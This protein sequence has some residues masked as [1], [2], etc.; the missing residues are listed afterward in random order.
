M[1]NLALFLDKQS[2]YQERNQ[3]RKKRQDKSWNRGPYIPVAP[4]QMQGPQMGY[5]QQFM[6]PM[7]DM[8]NIR[9]RPI[10]YPAIYT[11]EMMYPGQ[12]MPQPIPQSRPVLVE[13]PKSVNS[14]TEAAPKLLSSNGPPKTLHIDVSTE[15]ARQDLVRQHQVSQCT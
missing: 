12:Y 9:N 13:P 5:P 11:Q 1:Y 14:P 2:G 3:F 15:E 7:G 8:M 6:P 4:T 10:G